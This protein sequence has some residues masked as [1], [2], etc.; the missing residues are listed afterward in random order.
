AVILL[1][2]L[3]TVLLAWLLT[4]SIVG[5][6]KNAVQAAQHVADGD[7]TKRIEVTGSD[8]VSQLQAALARMQQR[9]R[10]TLAEISG[11]STQLA[12]AAVELNAVTE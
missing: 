2:A 6:L 7:L 4:R 8:E 3:V 11:S 10:E 12:A 1:A 9:L 5:P